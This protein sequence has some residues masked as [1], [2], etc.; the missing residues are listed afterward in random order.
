[1][2]EETKDSVSTESCAWRKTNSPF[3]LSAFS[4][5]L[6]SLSYKTGELAKLTPHLK[7]LHEFYDAALTSVATP[8]LDTNARGI[9]SVADI[10]RNKKNCKIE[11]EAAGCLIKS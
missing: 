9:S 7:E 10:D 5:N 2:N 3:V 8:S 4:G 1:M 11:Q 6:G